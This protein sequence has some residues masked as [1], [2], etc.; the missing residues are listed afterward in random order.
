MVV[1]KLGQNIEVGNYIV[2]G[3]VLGRGAGLRIGKILAI[4]TKND[5]TYNNIN[6]Y[7]TVHHFTV[8]GVNDGWDHHEPKLLTKKS[9]LLFNTRIIVLKPEML[10]HKIKTLLDSYA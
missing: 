5:Y 10:P 2:Y 7:T 1:D 6:T 4:K 3:R 8:I 9:T